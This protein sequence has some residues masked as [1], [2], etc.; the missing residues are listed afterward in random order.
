VSVITWA[1][2]VTRVHYNNIKY[3]I[4]IIHYTHRKH[5]EG[6]KHL[7]PGCCP[8]CVCVRACVCAC[9]YVCPVVPDEL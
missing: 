6:N 4:Y 1:T 5:Y 8:V 7:H 3:V 9:V 2:T